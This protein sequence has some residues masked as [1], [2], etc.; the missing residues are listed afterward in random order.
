MVHHRH[1]LKAERLHVIEQSGFHDFVGIDTVLLA[2]G[3]TLV[4]EADDAT[5]GLQVGACAEVIER[6]GHGD[7]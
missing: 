1:E 6:N 3:L 7:S 5:Q 2:M 4:E